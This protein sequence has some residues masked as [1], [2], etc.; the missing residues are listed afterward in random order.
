ML[1]ALA[2]L[3]DTVPTHL[4][5]ARTRRGPAARSRADLRFIDLAHCMVRMRQAGTHGPSLVFAADPPVPIELYDDLIATLQPNYRL[6]VLELPGFGCSLPRIGFRYSMTHAVAALEQLLDALGQGPHVLVLPCVSGFIGLQLARERP[7]LVRALVLPQ[8][9]D[10]AGA[11]RWL[12]GRD[13]QGLLRRPL[14]GQIALAALRHQRIERWYASALADRS[15]APRYAAATRTHFGQGACFG[16]ASAFQDFLGDAGAAF[17]PI[18]Q[19]TLVIWGD[20]DPSHAATDP[21]ATRALL[22]RGRITRFA[23]AGHFPELEKPAE[24][25]AELDRFIQTEYPT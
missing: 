17:A 25:C 11:R 2:Q 22:T 16:L 14:I 23:Q 21:E 7:D 24:F 20:R 5:S 19:P 18:A 1:Q 9:P 6:T 10:W 13:P 15:Q 12:H 8:T 4:R 3:I